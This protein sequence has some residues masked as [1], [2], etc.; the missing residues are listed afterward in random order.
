M[1]WREK[2]MFFPLCFEAFNKALFGCVSSIYG[3]TVDVSRG[4]TIKVIIHTYR[5]YTHATLSYGVTVKLQ[6]YWLYFSFTAVWML[7]SLAITAELNASEKLIEWYL[8]SQLKTKQ[9]CQLFLFVRSLL[10]LKSQEPKQQ[11]DIYAPVLI[12]ISSTESES[13]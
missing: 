6:K 7:E 3:C 13:S 4:P 8:F 12:N 9:M 5:I 10:D 2:K 11:P 1:V